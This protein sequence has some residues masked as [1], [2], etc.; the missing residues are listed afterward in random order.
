MVLH[1]W[2]SKYLSFQL[3]FARASLS[4]LPS[5]RL[6]LLLISYSDN[7]GRGKLQFSCG[8]G[9]FSRE[10]HENSSEDDEQGRKGS[11]AG[12]IAVVETKE[13]EAVQDLLRQPR[14]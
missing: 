13:I 8:A 4:S 14:K 5:V 10:S 9:C 11:S 3:V 12:S 7:F 2:A 1:Q 6:S